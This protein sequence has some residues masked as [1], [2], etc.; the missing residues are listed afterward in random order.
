MAE[1]IRETAASELRAVMRAER[2]ALIGGR[3]SDAV[4]MARRKAQ[5][6]E[7]FDPSG[8]DPADL[9]A[10]LRMSERNAELLRAARDG[11]AAAVRRLSE[12]ESAGT[13][14]TYGA[15]LRLRRRDSR[16]ALGKF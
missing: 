1:D 10:L 6:L 16:T 15:D 5:V 9:G 2:E 3:L 4:E 7:T 14:V 12:L 13:G 11:I 8:H